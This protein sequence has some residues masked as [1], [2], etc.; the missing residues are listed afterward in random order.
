MNFFH[1]PPFEEEGDPIEHIFDEEDD[2]GDETQEPD[3]TEEFSLDDEG[4]EDNEKNEEEELQLPKEIERNDGMHDAEVQ[5]IVIEPS[6]TLHTKAKEFLLQQLHF[7]GY[8]EKSAS[9]CLKLFTQYLDDPNPFP[10]CAI[11]GPIGFSWPQVK[12]EFPAFSPIAEIA[13][14]LHSSPC[15][16]ASC[17]RTISTQKLILNLRRQRSSADLLDARLK[18][19]RAKIRK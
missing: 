7:Q 5:T 4:E 6:P 14:K 10:T 16:E 15:S 17:E 9:T 13:M 18:L 3:G 19:M 11:D 8:S 1:I 2:S 12:K